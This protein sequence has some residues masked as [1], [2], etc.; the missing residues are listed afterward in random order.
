M[1]LTQT[2]KYNILTIQICKHIQKYE[3]NR[4]EALC[5]IDKSQPFSIHI[6]V[7]LH[8]SYCFETTPRFCVISLVILYMHLL[9][10]SSLLPHH[11][12]NI[13]ITIKNNIL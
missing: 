1:L 2:N 13:S 4:N 7:L 10:A 6:P 12:Y 9:K 8:F 5:P 11:N 3:N